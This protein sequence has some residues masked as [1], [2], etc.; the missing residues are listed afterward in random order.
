MQ[1]FRLA[2]AAA[3]FALGSLGMAAAE[4][5][6][7]QVNI[8]LTIGCPEVVP[9]RGNGGAVTFRIK[10]SARYILYIKFFPKVDE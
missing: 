1:F 2:I 8:G 10:N 6:C 3:F 7:D 4:E 5:D 9:P